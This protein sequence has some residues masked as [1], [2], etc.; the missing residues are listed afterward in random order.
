[1]AHCYIREQLSW[2]LQED[3][4][5]LMEA[6]SAAT[7]AQKVWRTSTLPKYKASCWRKLYMPLPWR[8]A[9]THRPRA[10]AVHDDAEHSEDDVLMPCSAAQ[11][12]W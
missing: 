3:G 10:Q 9:L 6:S 1:M 2:P 5:K 11:F 7:P 8:P 12:F 4:F